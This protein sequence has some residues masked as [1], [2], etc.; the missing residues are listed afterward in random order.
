MN[1]FQPINFTLNIRFMKAIQLTAFGI[2]NLQLTDVALPEIGSQ[3][4]LVE[5]KAVSL[6]YLDRAIVNGHYN[7]KLQLPRIPFS[8]GAGIVAAVGRN[9]TKWKAGD[10]VVAH[11]YQK[12]IAG[13]RNDENAHSQLGQASQGVL[14][15]YALIPDYGLV[16]AP[17][18]LSFEQS[19]TLSIAGLAAWTG[20]FE[21]AGLRA[22][23]SIVTIGSGAVS[24]FALQLASAAGASVIATSSSDNKLRSLT[25]LGASHTINTQ[26][27]TNWSEEV[28][29][30]TGDQG[31]DAILDVGGAATISQS[32]QSVKRHGFVGV[33]GFLGG[34]V[35]TVDFFRMITYNIRLQGLSGGSRASFES[36][37]AALEANHIEPVIDSVFSIEKTRDAFYYL[38]EKSTVGKV[39]ITI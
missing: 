5:M 13:N 2:E 32:I 37:I 6:N 27:F 17:I 25:S 11:Y 8:D 33:I 38:E 28:R 31:V 1:A 3:D 20:L 36:M 30:I 34:P 21:L 35:L 24:L 15:E 23:E 16:R 19:S 10:K 4:V 12:W 22:G 39:V 14:A 26:K 29:R 18:H 9:V 7:S